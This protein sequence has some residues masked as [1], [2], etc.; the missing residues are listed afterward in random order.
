[1]TPSISVII[2]TLGRPTLLRAIGSVRQQLGEHDEVLVIGDRFIPDV[3]TTDSR[4]QPLGDFSSLPSQYGNRQRNLGHATAA[5][6]LLCYLDDDDWHA[7]D[8][9]GMIRR[10]A[11]ACRVLHGELRPMIFRAIG[12]NGRTVWRDQVLRRRNVGTCMIVLPNVRQKLAEWPV[13]DSVPPG[14]VSPR[15]TDFDFIAETIALWGGP[16]SIVWRPEVIYCCDRV[17]GCGK[18]DPRAA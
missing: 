16:S 2:P 17:K 14:G 18:F 13:D 7:A 9:L 5:G 15:E 1:M 10:A 4:V 3:A 11:E 8:S 6:D 12:W